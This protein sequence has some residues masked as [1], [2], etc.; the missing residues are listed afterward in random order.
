MSC[1]L[2]ARAVVAY[3]KLVDF[4]QPDGT[5]V[6][7]RL[8]GDE[9]IKYA[10]T[11]DGYSLLYDAEG[12]LVYAQSGTNGNM[13]PSVIR[14]SDPSMRSTRTNEFL[15]TVPQKL[16]F[17]NSQ[18]ETILRDSKM[19]QSI[20]KSRSQALAGTNSPAVGKR[21]FLTILVEFADVKFT[22]TKED[23]HQ[24][25]N[26]EGY[27][28]DGAY[29]SVRDFY[30]ENSFGKLDLSTDVA[31]IYTLPLRMADYGGNSNGGSDQNPWLMVM[32]AVQMA[33]KD[34]NFAEYD[35]DKDGIVDGLHI[36]F[37]GHGEEAG[38]GS[39][40]I[41]SH[42]S[43]ISARLDGVNIQKYSCSPILR[44]S[45]GD[46]LTHIGVI[47][48][49]I[50]HVLG[51]M[52]YY[53]TNYGTGGNYPGCG[54]WDLM[55]SGNWNA[56]GAYPAHFNPYVKAY[57]FGWV[58]VIDGN[59]PN[60]Y[61]LKSHSEDGVIRIDTKTPDEY[62]LLEYRS[63]TGFDLRIP[64][65]GLMIYRASEGLSRMSNN[66]INAHHKQQFYPVCANSDYELPNNNP[67]SYGIVNSTST[68]FSDLSGNDE[69]TDF[70]IPSMKSWLNVETGM[71]V[72]DIQED[73]ASNQVSFN[74][75]GGKFGGAYAFKVK[76]SDLSSITVEWKKRA[77][78]EVLLVANTV[79]SFGTPEKK[80]YSAGEN[81]H[82]GGSVIYCGKS[83]EYRHGGLAE[84]TDMYFKLFTRLPDNSW[85]PGITITGR[86]ETGIVR[87]FP[88]LEDF[89]TGTLEKQWK[90]EHIYA[91]TDW[92][93]D[94]LFET[95]GYQL[96]YLLDNNGT[97]AHRSRQK[98]RIVMPTIDFRGKNIAVLSFDSR[99]YL[100]TIEV[101]YRTSPADSWK[102]L[103][104]LDS[105]HNGT[106]IGQ[107]TTD[108]IASNI[109]TTI[110]LPNLTSTYE[111]SFVADYIQR[112]S[113]FSSLEI[114]TI[115]NIK[116]QVDYP[117]IAYSSP[118]PMIGSSDAVMKI[119]II[120]GLDNA[121]E[122]GV[123]WSSDEKVWTAVTADETGAAH[124]HGLPLGS[125]FYYR[126]YAKTGTETVYEDVH[127]GK[128][129]N[130]KH[131]S[132]T[133]E[134]P[135]TIS[136]NNEWDELRKMVE[137]GNLC[138]NVYFEL[139]E[140][141]TL[142]NC[143]KIK[144]PF[145]GNLN[146]NGYSLTIPK[147]SRY[148]ALFELLNKD[149]HVQN[150]K[151]IGENLVTTE[152]R[153]GGICVYNTGV[154]CGCEISINN[155]SSTSSTLPINI[156]GVCCDNLGYI[157]DC[158]S[159]VNFKNVQ[160]NAGGICWY[161]YG[162]ISRC[163]FNGSL[164]SNNNSQLGGIASINFNGS[165]SGKDTSGI[166]TDCVSEGTLSSYLE[167]N[168]AWYN[169]IGGIAA[170]NYGKIL[171]CVNNAS[172]SS[173]A[174]NEVTQNHVGGI[175]GGNEHGF[176]KDCINFS[177]I[178]LSGSLDLHIAGGITGSSYLG[179]VRNSV[180][181][182]DV[183]FNGTKT[184]VINAIIGENN[185]TGL[186]NCWYSGNLSISESGVSKINTA[187]ETVDALNENREVKI[188]SV[189][190]SAIAVGA[191]A[192]YTIPVADYILDFSDT[193][194]KTRAIAS[195]NDKTGQGYEWKGSSGDWMRVSTDITSDIIEVELNDLTPVSPYHL[196]YFIIDK[197]GKTT[198]SEEE[199]FSTTFS[200]S[201][202][203]NDPHSINSLDELL[204]FNQMVSHGLNFAGQTVRLTTDIDLHGD[205]GT[206]WHPLE[207]ELYLNSGFNGEFDGGGKVIRNMKIDTDRCYA[208]FA[209]YCNGYIH[210]LILE[211]ADITCTT[212]GS[213]NKY[214]A[215]VG[216]FIGSCI[217]YTTDYEFLAERCGFIGKIN[218]G[219]HVGGIIG[220]STKGNGIKDCF[221][222]GDIAC[223]VTDDADY[224][225]A[226]GITGSAS[227]AN[228]YFVG[229]VSALSTNKHG[230]S[231]ITGNVYD[232]NINI[233][234]CYYDCEKYKAWA[235]RGAEYKAANDMKSTDF[236]N[237]LSD[238]WA[239]NDNT[240]DGLPVFKSIGGS[241]V[242]TET[243]TMDENADVVLTGMYVTGIDA[244]Y[245]NRGIQWYSKSGENIHINDFFE[246]DENAT[247]LTAVI[248][249][250]LI[251]N[252]GINFR[253]MATDG[254]DSI[255]G[256]WK[257]YDPA[258]ILPN[259][260]IFQYESSNF[261]NVR[262][263]FSIKNGSEEIDEMKLFYRQCDENATEW[264]TISL[265]PSA[266]YIDLIN[267]LPAE[268][269]E[270]YIRIS[271]KSG[272]KSDGT[273]I[274]F[275][276]IDNRKFTVT[277][278]IGE[279][280]IDSKTLMV[281]ETIIAPVAP[282]KEG[283]LFDG[284][285]DLPETMPA[286]DL[287]IYGSYSQYSSIDSILING[288][289]NVT[290][291]TIGGMIICKDIKWS[292]IVGKLPIGIYIIN[293]KKTTI[294][295]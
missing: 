131:G 259:A 7:I 166:I 177:N 39:D 81:L 161:N 220:A 274:T 98:T 236:A 50:G 90:N 127:K 74:V 295:R 245:K 248:K 215:G 172:I 47:C 116:I 278:M 109:N 48:H 64:G 196:R 257:T 71:P 188:W 130:F 67:S 144:K 224:M 194:V 200:T 100:Q 2:T 191:L 160:L 42:S 76:D 241:R 58:N 77:D 29:G 55:S 87:E 232:G 152:W 3:P 141:I 258:I 242:I 23:V 5:V 153:T 78:E 16:S 148:E 268:E 201:G 45:H 151:L 286:H 15:T 52:D 182:G 33:D 14:A 256:E 184:S 216:G 35:N 234:N 134:S 12:A 70:T 9:N 154:I 82:G 186:S 25:M 108:V 246:S 193:H 149:A 142:S 1:G 56:D 156:G 284:W 213:K 269:Y 169:C 249:N 283:Y 265:D 189:Y 139:T 88:Y 233:E 273:T 37:A 34:V 198:Y 150:I 210:D 136:N 174:Q 227:V 179:I 175:V 79:N 162:V 167:N 128:T 96:I 181:Y 53:D 86:T 170:E 111:I 197:S 214:Y 212:P 132:G 291:F 229:T 95:A 146:G 289:E 271:T 292:D 206:L 68:P 124:L 203:E 94:R 92:T 41:W 30:L 147:N 171:R 22:H 113:A 264:N 168:T 231:A 54:N 28:Q 21:K 247:E 17:S 101:A 126:A 223:G 187:E 277:F 13:E 202:T 75:G 270:A 46:H 99:N 84:H 255:F 11:E 38:G 279:E 27:N 40:C 24:L 211:N 8:L 293:G 199:A 287:N 285:K 281:G 19:Y 235:L 114:A 253:A 115:D 145:N 43:S 239:Q 65:H 205:K 62:F 143:A 163:R 195:C 290:I 267:L 10:E 266:E 217:A 178:A 63:Q 121:I 252:E 60:S 159:N 110:E 204:A 72:S 244:G 138:T 263:F 91:E 272:Y 102:T 238:V 158:T 183:Y 80:I 31:G 230:L 135:F 57:D 250:S 106:A 119:N 261:D 221:V 85:T 122:S 89:E 237:K 20:Q 6:K 294:T 117:V 209:A 207:S 222:I 18:V 157:Y 66:T 93:V 112:G 225:L 140:N 125:T 120:N 129:S 123:E 240:N 155:I 276:S 219:S 97:S 208:G 176:I 288:N 32:Q 83:T 282:E 275:F 61:T 51:A 103:K 36:L 105:Q 165:R 4:R 228:S 260:I 59:Q 73:M 133:I 104:T 49:E 137:S 192:D 226:G 218:G 251:G 185:Q 44:G 26:A 280:I 243:A 262:L 180:A 69:F 164:A 118:N 190:N 254:K 107:S 173:I